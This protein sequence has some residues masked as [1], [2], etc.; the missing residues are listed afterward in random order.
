MKRINFLWLLFSVV[1]CFGLM[2]CKDV[3]EPDN[4]NANK[5]FVYTKTGM[6]VGITGFSNA[7][8]FYGSDDG[9]YQ[10]LSNSKPYESFINGLSMGDATV[11]YYAVDNNLSYLEKCAFP[12]DV[13]SV[14]IITFTDGLDQGSRALDKQDQNNSYTANSKSYVEAIAEK[15][16]RIKV[17]N[18]PINAYAIGVRG[19]DIESDAVATFENNLLKLSSSKENAMQVSNMDE[20]NAKFEAIAK[21]LYSKT[22]THSLTIT[23]P[24]PSEKEKERFTFDDVTDPTKSKCYLEGVYA[25]GA[26]NGIKY[27]GCQSSSGEKVLE[28]NAGGVKIQFLFENFTDLKGN[29]ISTTKMQQWHM[30]ESVATWTRNSEFKPTESINVEEKRTSA[31]VM[32]ILDCSSSLGA[33]DFAKVKSAAVNFVKTLAGEVTSK[34]PDTPDNPDTPDTPDNP[35]TPDTPDNPN[36]PDNPNP[37]TGLTYN[38]TVPAGTNACYIAGEMTTWTQQ[39]MTKVDDTHYTITFADATTDMQYKYCSGPSWEYVEIIDRNRVYSENDVVEAW[40][41]IYN[42]NEIPTDITYNVTVPNGT[43]TCYIV[44]EMTNWDFRE[45]VKVD[46]LHYTLTI[47]NATTNMKYRYLSGPNWDYVETGYD[48]VYSASD[49]VEAWTALYNPND[50]P[51]QGEAKDIIIKAKVPAEWTDEITAWVWPTGG[52]GHIVVPTKE[53]DWYVYSQYSVELNI[54]FRNG[55]DWNGDKNQTVDITL[56]ESACIEITAGL[57]KA[58]YTQVDCEGDSGNIGNENGHSWVDLGLSV[59]WATCNVGANNPE[60]YGGY[61]AWG[62]TTTKTYY[63]WDTYKHSISN[64]L[65]ITKYCTNSSYGT[66]DNKTTLELSDDAARA[67]WGGRWRMPTSAEITELHEQ[68]TWSWTTQNGVSG[69]KVTSRINGQYIFLPATGCSTFESIVEVGRQGHYWA[70]SLDEE[71]TPKA[72]CIFF[73][74]S[75]VNVTTDNR[76]AGRAVRPVCL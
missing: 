26:L 66:V 30:E 57:D 40:R 72:H 65:D 67:N 28:T 39:E 32:L 64:W 20:V 45:M 62:E 48:R 19:S 21:S 38:V 46:E 16:Q 74:D 14:S 8:K 76:D 59:K 56:T 5:D 24:M 53:G 15:L 29:A 11:L 73:N 50:L 58:T 27:V 42:P 13:S 7:I 17:N 75:Y 4:P 51:N 10:I 69:Y 43:Y 31:V 47:E 60:E 22:E 25:N 36:N 68:C 6:Y 61:F 34:E 35:D 33:S 52:E 23:I 12:E 55:A 44:G 70:S 18:L 63:Y 2:S 41:A 3:N 49:I 9:R 54:I 71:Y 1:C 37:N